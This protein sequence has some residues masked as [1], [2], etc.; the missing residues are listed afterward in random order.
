MI[1]YVSCLLKD[2][3]CINNTCL[4]EYLC[5][6]LICNWII[7]K[8]IHILLYSFYDNLADDLERIWNAMGEESW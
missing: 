7:F 4:I 5:N 1:D 3:L 8:I 6:K 2:F